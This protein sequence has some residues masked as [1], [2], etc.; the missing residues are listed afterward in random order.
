MRFTGSTVGI[1]DSTVSTLKQRRHARELV[2][3]KYIEMF[4]RCINSESGDQSLFSQRSFLRLRAGVSGTRSPGTEPRG[5]L[6]LNLLFR[7]PTSC[8]AQSEQVKSAKLVP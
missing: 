4:S 6:K 8:L 1:L 7:I 2:Y 3:I 5:C